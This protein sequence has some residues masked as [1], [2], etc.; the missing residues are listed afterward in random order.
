MTPRPIREIFPERTAGSVRHN[1]TT[2]QPKPTRIFPIRTRGAIHFPSASHPARAAVP[3]RPGPPSL[4]PAGFP[5]PAIR[6]F[7]RS[8]TDIPQTGHRTPHRLSPQ[9]S[10]VIV[11]RD[12]DIHPTWIG[13]EEQQMRPASIFYSKI[14]IISTIFAIFEIRTYPEVCLAVQSNET[15]KATHPQRTARDVLCTVLGY[16][17]EYW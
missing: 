11:R 10:P 8:H 15:T 1:H 12:S 2:A 14:W 6:F 4:R 3:S 17:W 5:Q 7:L 13:P 16:L 9:T